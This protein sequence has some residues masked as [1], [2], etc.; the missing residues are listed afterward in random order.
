M[1]SLKTREKTYMFCVD[2]AAINGVQCGPVFATEVAPGRKSN[3]EIGFLSNELEKTALA[4]KQIL[5]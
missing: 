1:H 5:N 3:E 4:I 2:S